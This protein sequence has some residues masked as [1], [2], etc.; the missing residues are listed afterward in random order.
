VSLASARLDG[1]PQL[2]SQIVVPADHVSLHRH[3]QS[4]L[5]VRR[6]LLEQLAELENFPSE[7]PTTVA[8]ADAD[9]RRHRA[10][11]EHRP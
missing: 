8:S 5:E 4:I 6:V 3:P 11:I 1:S 7:R 10:A 9:L 2:R